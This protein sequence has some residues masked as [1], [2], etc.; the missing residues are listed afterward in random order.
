VRLIADSGALAVLAADVDAVRSLDVDVPVVDLPGVPA[1]ACPEPVRTGEAPADGVAYTIFTSGTSGTPKGVDVPHGAFDNLVQWYV[2][3]FGLD[4]D[5]RVP[6]LASPAFDASLLE[7]APTLA[8]GACVVVVADEVRAD[9]ARL[10]EFLAARAVTRPFIVTPLFSALAAEPGLAA[11]RALRSVQVGGDRL[12]AVPSVRLPRLSNLYGPT[13][14]GV[15]STSGTQVPGREPHIGT[16]IEGTTA[17]IVDDYLRPVTRGAIGELYVG[18]AGV[19]RGYRNDPGATAVAF[20][21]DPFGASG[22]RL[23]RTGDLMSERADGTL[24]YHGRRDDQIAL[25]GH[26]IERAEIEAA[27]LRVDGVREAAVEV[28]SDGA[29]RLVAHVLL[30]EHGAPGGILD[31]LRNELPVYMVPAELYVHDVWPLTP[32]GKV[33]R[34]RL[35]ETRRAPVVE[36]RVPPRGAVANVVAGVWAEVLGTDPAGTD[37]FFA[38]GGHSLLAARRASRLASGLGIDVPLS[39][40]FE[41]SRLQELADELEGRL[42]AVIRA[43]S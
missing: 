38:Q 26:R 35:G 17:H 1:P 7:I 2:D 13:E 22:A 3:E 32:A 21:P 19:A 9:P 14:A 36:E 16:P 10:A 31:E 34:R 40:I 42:L 33:D 20:V 43:S 18:G 6:L 5:D 4:V 11:C 25:R 30:S 15:V 23:Y 39:T 28:D 29:T 41:H 37:D 8:A 27:L 24:T 12:A